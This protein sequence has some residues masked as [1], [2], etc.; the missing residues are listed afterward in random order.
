MVLSGHTE[1]AFR[2]RVDGSLLDNNYRIATANEVMT[3]LQAAA[4]AYAAATLDFSKKIPTL[5]G[6]C[7]EEANSQRAVII[8]Q[9]SHE[10]GLSIQSRLNPEFDRMLAQ[11]RLF[12]SLATDR[13]GLDPRISTGAPPRPDLRSA[14]IG[15]GPVFVMEASNF[16]FAFGVLGGDSCSALAAGCPVVVKSHPGHPGTSELLLQCFHRAA[17]KAGVPSAFLS[18]VHCDTDGVAAAIQHP[19]LRGLGFTGSRAVGRILRQLASARPRP[20][21]EV[22]LEMGSVNPVF[23]TGR[24]LQNSLSAGLLANSVLAGGGQ[25]CTKPGLLIAP[26]K[27]QGGQFVESFLAVL[28]AAAPVVLLSERISC[29]WEESLN[30]LGDL[31]SVETILPSFGLQD[32]GPYG[33]CVCQTDIDSLAADNL[34]REE[35]FGP[36]CLLVDCPEDRFSHAANLFEGELTATLHFAE[37][38]VNAGKGFIKAFA[39]KAGRLVFNG[40]PT[41]VEICEALNHGGPWPSA[42]GRF[43]SVGHQSIHRWTRP[44]CFQNA[45][46]ALLPEYLHG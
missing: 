18:M 26:F 6:L 35:V 14:R 8:G 41:G 31:T 24:A 10:T 1:S 12:A 33:P 22:S 4:E 30:R 21:D 23:L 43:S 19:D 17:A 46:I 2:S 39:S 37:D 32:H 7:E 11:M 28:K 9:C 38:E 42:F 20:L 27:S 15:I 44:L 36:F 3:T 40:V 13:V 45:P 29:S 34:L 16:P 25:F 5:L